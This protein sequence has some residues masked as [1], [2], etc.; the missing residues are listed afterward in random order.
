MLEELVA[1]TF[2]RR[3]STGRTVPLLL[4]GEHVDELEIEVVAKF[5]KGADIGPAGLTREALCALLAADL[6]L[7]IPTLT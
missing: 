4:A 2:H 6:G 3:M 1:T 7:P 5:S